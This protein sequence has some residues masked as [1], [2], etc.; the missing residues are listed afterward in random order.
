MNTVWSIF[1][2]QVP[3]AI[4]CFLVARELRGIKAALEKIA[5]FTEKLGNKPDQK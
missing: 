1:L 3:I 2:T 4:A 5:T